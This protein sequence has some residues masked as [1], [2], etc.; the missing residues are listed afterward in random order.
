MDV[1]IVVATYGPDH[2]REL[3]ATRAIPSALALGVPV[4]HAHADTL[5]EARNLGVSAVNTEW[6]VHLDADDE[7]EPGYLAELAAGT[8]DLRAPSVRYLEPSRPAPAAA[9]PHVVG[10]RHDCSADCLPEGNFMVVGTAVR[11]QLVRD[12]GGWRD[13]P[14]WEDWDLWIRCWLAGASIETV[15]AAVYRAHVDP[16][17]RNRRPSRAQRQQAHAEIHATNFGDR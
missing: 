15:P 1:T 4:V 8:A 11:T 2:W 16:A 3:A 10:H 13:L 6:T 12:V 17:S 14:I 5:H 9:V 7:L